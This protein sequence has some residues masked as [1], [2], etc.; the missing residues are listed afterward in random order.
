[1]ITLSGN[2]QKCCL[3]RKPSITFIVFT[4]GNL[5]LMPLQRKSRLTLCLF[6]CRHLGQV[7]FLSSGECRPEPHL[8]KQQVPAKALTLRDG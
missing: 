2:F 3:F 7:S 1:M 8:A 6:I 5:F 4:I